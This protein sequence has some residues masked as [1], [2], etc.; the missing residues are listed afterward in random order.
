MLPN[1]TKEPLQ[2]EFEAKLTP[3]EY[4]ALLRKRAGMTRRQ[5]AQA[6]DLTGVTVG[7]A[8]REATAPRTI[9]WLIRFMEEHYGNSNRNG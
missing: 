4:L 1:G 3:G 6:T 8:E 9:D 2:R 7:R 5:V